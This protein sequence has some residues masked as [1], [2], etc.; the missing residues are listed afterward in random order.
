[1]SYENWESRF[2][3]VG[4][5]IYSSSNNCEHNTSFQ[6]SIDIFYFYVKVICAKKEDRTDSIRLHH[7]RCCCHHYRDRLRVT[8][9]SLT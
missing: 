7:H 9:T 4:L 1:M 6:L 3:R 5:Q 8:K 2:V